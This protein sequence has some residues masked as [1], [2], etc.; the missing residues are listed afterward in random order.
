MKLF[1]ISGWSGSGKTTLIEHL[2]PLFTARGLKV[3]LVKHTHHGFDIDRPGKDSFRFREAGASEVMLAGAARWALMR[4]LRDEDQP[5][6]AE[7]VS[8][9]SP[10]DLVLVEG[11]KSA[12]LPKIEVHRPA[13]GKPFFHTEFP[14]VVAIA[15]DAPLAVELPVLDLNDPPAIAAYILRFT[16]LA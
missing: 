5:T 15:S 11:F 7:L 4:E 8:H 13:V 16:E 9:L 1:G 10:C 14:N 12:E 6:L 3:S 2:I